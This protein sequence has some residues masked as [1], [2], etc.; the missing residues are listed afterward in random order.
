METL[1]EAFALAYSIENMPAHG[2]EG[3][4]TRFVGRACE[5]YKDDK[6]DYWYR[7]GAGRELDKKRKI[8][9]RG[10]S[11]GKRRGSS[12]VSSLISILELG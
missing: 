12:P 6:G 7:S 9:W 10:K 2:A 8:I 3:R 4:S 5:L 1:D 11:Q